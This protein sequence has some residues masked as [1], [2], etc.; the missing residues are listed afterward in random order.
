MSK[1]TILGGGV[2][3]VVWGYALA[4]PPGLI[5]ASRN[6]GL[7]LPAKSVN[8]QGA[9]S[10]AIDKQQ[11][12]AACVTSGL[13]PFP[14]PS[15]LEFEPIRRFV[16]ASERWA[17][18]GDGD[19]LG[20][21][22]E[23]AMALELHEP[24]LDYFAAA[25]AFGTDTARWT[26]FLGAE[27]QVIGAA[28]LAIKELEAAHAKDGSYATTSTR[29]GALYFELGDLDQADKWYEKATKGQP[30]PTAGVVGRGRVALAKREFQQA[31]GFLDS[32]VRAT[33][34][35]YIAHRL[36]SQALAR[37]GR[38]DEAAAA[39]LTS[40]Q[41]TPYRGWL[42][43]DPRLG[44][45]HRTAGTQHSLEIALNVAIGKGDLASAM[46]AGEE[47]LERLPKSPQILSVMATILA[48]SNQLPRA[49][50]LA[51]RACDVAPDDLQAASALANIA[52]N[53]GD[54]DRAAAAAQRLIELAPND[55]KTHQA[56]GRLSFIRGQVDDSIAHLRKA[57]EL[58]SENPVHHL[59][60][61]DVLIK[62]ERTAEAEGQL[63]RLLKVA[64][65]NAQANQLLK[66]IRGQ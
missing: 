17:E 20:R 18:T 29:L 55:P 27:C 65:K 47:L 41:L 28:Q 61:V 5:P 3:L 26:Y 48:N 13:P 35:D 45:A 49:M 4:G 50:E 38:S 1:L 39:A 34:S 56:L 31:L 30:F 6:A 15:G 37:L 12:Q 11:W 36:R 42:T 9:T 24:A 63:L 62:D 33:P 40:N 19:E 7:P 43:L 58:E 54:F 66:S 51:Q 23:I 53:I 44:D 64:P 46:K 21:M 25:R 59:M 60:L 32:A 16:A 22:G 52:T 8:D 14:D 57:I 2:A 10:A